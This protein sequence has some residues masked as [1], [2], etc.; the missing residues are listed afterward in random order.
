MASARGRPED[1]AVVP[2][3]QRILQLEASPARL[4]EALDTGYEMPGPDRGLEPGS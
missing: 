4:V 3:L 2:Q 1:L